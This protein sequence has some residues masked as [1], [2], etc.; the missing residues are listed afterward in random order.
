MGLTAA[1]R[2]TKT[3]T[4]RAQNAAPPKIAVKTRALS[5]AAGRV[6]V[7]VMTVAVPK[8]GR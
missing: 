5:A 4:T 3:L 2:A 6:A 1:I 8:R 7:A